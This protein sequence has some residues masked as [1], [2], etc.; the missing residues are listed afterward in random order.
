MHPLKLA[1]IVSGA[2]LF[3]G[4]GCITP[5][6]AGQPTSTPE[7]ATT[8]PGEETPPVGTPT[9]NNLVEGTNQPSG[10]SANVAHVALGTSGYVVIHENANGGPGA[11]LGA[12]ALLSAGVHNNVSVTLKR[13]SKAGETLYAMLHEDDG[14][15][16]YAFPDEDMPI[17][18]AN[19]KVVLGS[20]VI[21]EETPAAE[22]PEEPTST[23]EEEEQAAVETRV[24]N[25]QAGNFFFS[26]DSLRLTKGQPVKIEVSNGGFHSFTVDELGVDA[27]IRGSSSIVEFTP[28]KTGTFTY[29]CNVPGHREAGMMGTVVVE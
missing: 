16:V 27:P 3:A 1:A 26:P 20:F 5:P 24:M 13:E 7:A 6:R 9:R 21:L 11:V 17:K 28:T 8:A 2:L 12:S 10:M 18:D 22:P 19:G 25:M 4:A 23:P 15:G 29:Y 14:D